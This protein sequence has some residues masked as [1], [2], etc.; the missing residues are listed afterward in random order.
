MSE[1]TDTPHGALRDYVAWHDDYADPESSLSA[2]LRVV[3]AAIGDW[4]AASPGPRRVL[5]VC[6]GQGHDIIGALGAR[7]AADRARVSGSLVEIDPTNAAIAR[8]RIAELGLRLD[9]VQ[10]DAG[11]SDTLV[12]LVPADLVLLVGI[13]G[14]ISPAD[15]ERLVATARELTAPGGTVIWSQGVHLAGLNRQIVEWFARAG[16]EEQWLGVV[17]ALGRHVGVERL[18]AEPAPLRPGR[19]IFTFHR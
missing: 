9:V 13:M 4:L 5:S 7:S 6:A 17:D 19:T 10:A 2:R 14:N 11:L 12:G 3:Q 18:V 1:P 16:F 8:R 15:I